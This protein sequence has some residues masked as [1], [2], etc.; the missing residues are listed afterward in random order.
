[1]QKSEGVEIGLQISKLAEDVENALPLGI[2]S[3]EDGGSGFANSFSSGGHRNSATSIKDAGRSV[4]DSGAEAPFQAAL[5]RP[6]WVGTVR[7]RNPLSTMVTTEA[8]SV[9]L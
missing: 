1:T 5:R 2:G 9:A 8:A 3:I 4:L 7:M 6:T